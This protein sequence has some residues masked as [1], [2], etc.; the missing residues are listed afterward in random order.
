MFSEV[1]FRKGIILYNFADFWKGSV[2]LVNT[3]TAMLSSIVFLLITIPSLLSRLSIIIAIGSE[4][5]V[6]PLSEMKWN[7]YNCSLF[8]SNEDCIVDPR[9]RF[10][11]HYNECNQ[12]LV[13][14]IVVNY[15][16]NMFASLPFLRDVYFPRFHQLFNYSFDVVYFAPSYRKNLRVVNNNLPTA[17][18]YSYY[19]LSLAY[20]IFGRANE[21]DYAGFF[22]MNDDGFIDPLHLN[23]ISLNE[24]FSEPSEVNSPNKTKWWAWNKNNTYGVTFKDAYY[25][26]IDEIKHSRLESKCMLRESINHR[27]GYYDF[28]FITSRDIALY[29][30]LS[31]LFFKHRVFLELAGPTINWCLSHKTIDSCNHRFWKTVRT[32]VHLHPVKHTDKANEQLI[33]DHI[34][35]RNMSWVAKM[36]YYSVFYTIW[37]V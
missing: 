1:S 6:R 22:F 20:R 5:R 17:G 36:W 2:L 27:R 9:Q 30:E 28:A 29:Y 25:S 13:Y 12:S 26:T 31:L 3:V 24:S 37:C 16:W 18:Y 33:L 34:N 32:C 35:R 14:L 23:M 15:H 4:R 19:S 10:I 7:N 8:F 11:D 21:Y